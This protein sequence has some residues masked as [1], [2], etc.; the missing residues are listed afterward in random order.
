MSLFCPFLSL[1]FKIDIK[2]KS[3]LKEDDEDY[4][5]NSESY[6][7]VSLCLGVLQTI[8][9]MISCVVFLY[10]VFLTGSKMLN[11]AK[12]L[13]SRLI[14]AQAYWNNSQVTLLH[15]IQPV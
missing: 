2:T 6:L 5:M 9:K 1:S 14:K 4:A 8:W 11:V 13:H 12:T 15:P 3:Q 10:F 7:E